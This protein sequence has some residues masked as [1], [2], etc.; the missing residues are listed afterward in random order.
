MVYNSLSF[1]TWNTLA[2]MQVNK[3]RF[4]SFTPHIIILITNTTM[5]IPAANLNLVSSAISYLDSKETKME[6]GS[7]VIYIYWIKSRKYWLESS[8][9]G[10]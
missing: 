7:F 3:R 2:W 1:L 9:K 10:C 6:R 4:S 8:K 5:D